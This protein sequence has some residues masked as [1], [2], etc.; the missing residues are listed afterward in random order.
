MTIL[1][2]QHLQCGGGALAPAAAAC[3][4]R[5]DTA[6][7][8]HGANRPA[9]GRPARSDA[10]GARR[11]VHRRRSADTQTIA[12]ER[13]TG[14]GRDARLKPSCST[15]IRASQSAT[16]AIGEIA[17]RSRTL[18]KGGRAADYRLPEPVTG[19]E[20]VEVRIAY[21]RRAACRAECALGWRLR[22]VGNRR[23]PAVDRHR[24]PGRG[25]RPV[26]A[27]H[28]PFLEAGSAR[29]TFW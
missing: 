7:R 27:L 5:H 1:T 19:G 23:R 16:S 28:R 12:G 29:S 2:W 14:F 26:L 3:G 9:A 15:S 22:L 17:L 21:D 13:G 20:T 8:P 24:R 18:D 4:A 25:L 6:A 11:A 10:T